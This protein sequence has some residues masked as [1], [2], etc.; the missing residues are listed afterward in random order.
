MELYAVLAGR[1]WTAC[2]AAFGEARGKII[3]SVLQPGDELPRRLK[4]FFFALTH[5]GSS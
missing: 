5:V 1:G 3:S 2:S 4:I